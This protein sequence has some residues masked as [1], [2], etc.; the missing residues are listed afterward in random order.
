[1]HHELIGHSGKV[2]GAAFFPD[3]KRII[4]AG[5]DGTARLWDSQTRNE[6]FA[7]RHSGPVWAVAVSHDGRNVLTVSQGAGAILWRPTE[8]NVPTPEVSEN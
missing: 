8:W 1:M 3:G 6:L 7:L 5:E 4:T 2:H